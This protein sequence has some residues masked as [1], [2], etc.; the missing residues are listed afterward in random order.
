MVLNQSHGKMIAFTAAFSVGALSVDAG[1]IANWKQLNSGSAIPTA[2]LNTDGPTF[3]DGTGGSA[4]SSFIAG[5][6]GTVGSP[7]SVTLAIG[8]TLTVSGNLTLVGGAGSDYRFGIFNDGGQ[9]A[10]NANDD[11]T[12]GWLHQTNADTYRARTGAG[13]IFVSTGGNAVDLD[14]DKTASG[15]FQPN[16]PN[17]PFNWTMSITRDSATTVDI[18]STISGGA[19]TGGGT[20]SR[21][22]T[23]IVNDQATSLF[24]YTAAGLLFSGSSS[25]DEGVFS[26]VHYAKYDP[27][28]ALKIDFGVADAPPSQT[29]NTINDI[30]D[31][32]VGMDARQIGTATDADQGNSVYATRTINGITITVSADDGDSRDRLGEVSGTGV[33]DLLEDFVFTRDDPIVLTLEGLVDGQDYELIT[34]H[35]DIGNFTHD[36]NWTIDQGDGGAAI[37]HGFATG[38]SGLTPTLSD[39]NGQLITTFTAG[40]GPV[41]ITGTKAGAQ[42]LRLN[43]LELSVVP[44]PSSLALLGLGGLLIARR[45]R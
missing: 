42:A 30:Q 12:G 16:S 36:S 35:H 26:S 5:Q 21:V 24:T 25:V 33:D 29:S 13:G 4:N 18:A 9:F 39:G 7:E 28:T 41:V 31:G 15:T 20:D 14:A 45:R 38:T 1:T 22:Q 27:T 6:F 3:G 11:W 10:L 2:D 34:Y 43:G 37:N 23:F 40:S 19:G 17:F 8:E 44:E 32:F